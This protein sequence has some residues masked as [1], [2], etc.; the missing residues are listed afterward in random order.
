MN[1]NVPE[2]VVVL[3]DLARC[4]VE[5][6]LY[7]GQVRFRPVAV[8]SAALVMRLKRCRDSLKSLLGRSVTPVPAADL[9]AWV[10]RSPGMTV[11]EWSA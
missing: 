7:D 3:E 8:V 6:A 11:A 5:L 1:G 4:G 2:I 10:R 9:A